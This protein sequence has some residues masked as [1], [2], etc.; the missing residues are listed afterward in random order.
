MG[1]IIKLRVLLMVALSLLAFSL[2]EHQAHSE[3]KGRGTKGMPPGLERKGGRL[4]PGFSKGEKRGFME[5]RPP[6]WRQ[7]EKKG[8]RDMLPPGLQKEKKR[9]VI[10]AFNKK[11]MDGERKIKQKAE[12]KKLGKNAL[13][14]A[15]LY[16]NLTARSGVP[17]E[18]AVELI[19]RMVE[20][21]A[22]PDTM[23]RASRAY[24]YGVGKKADYRGLGRFVAEKLKEG[25]SGDKLAVAIYD[26]I[27]RR[28]GGSGGD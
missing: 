7:G 12:G 13:N 8:W 25:Y 18:A 1:R 11:L 20:N 6:G 16:M 3:G 15:L 5:G 10:E 28:T 26:E 24:A 19:D 9:G 22:D 17:V 21:A 2:M 27:D 4:P 23:E 14:K